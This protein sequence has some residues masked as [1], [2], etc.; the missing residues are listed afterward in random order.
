MTDPGPW[1]FE[2]TPGFDLEFG[3]LD[4][5]I[6]RRI[7]AYL[8]DVAQLSDPRQR[9][10]ALTGNRREHWRYRVGDYRII[11]TI[12]DGH[13]VILALAAAKRSEAY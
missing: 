2:T 11:M 7:A 6:Q 5:T 4:S 3:K 12:D 13:L 9:G 10:K 8:L 1:R